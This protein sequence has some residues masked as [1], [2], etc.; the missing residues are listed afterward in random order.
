M[1]KTIKKEGCGQDLPKSIDTSN[2]IE[3]GKLIQNPWQAKKK[4]KGRLP[5]ISIQFSV[6]QF[7]YVNLS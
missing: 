4:L 6:I 2:R 3:G 5:I 7:L 1:S